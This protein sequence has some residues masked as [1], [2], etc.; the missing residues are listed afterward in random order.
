MKELSQLLA[1]SRG[2]RVDDDE[3][4]GLGERVASSARSSDEGDRRASAAA[5]QKPNLIGSAASESSLPEPSAPPVSERSI[6]TDNVASAIN[7]QPTAAAAADTPLSNPITLEPIRNLW[8]NLTHNLPTSER[9][10]GAPPPPPQCS[11]SPNDAFNLQHNKLECSICLDDYQ[12]NDTIAWAKDGGDPPTS[13]SN[14]TIAN[15]DNAGCD[16]I[17][18]KGCIVAWLQDHE[19]CP[20]CRRKVVHED[21][22][23]RFARWEST[24]VR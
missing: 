24:I 14:A 11:T 22:D 2:G 17:F 23:A 6:T 16:H 18:H 21:A 7:S 8:T 15:N 1:I 5:K 4:M 10:E 3:E 19:E 9:S 12:P 20:L 13:V